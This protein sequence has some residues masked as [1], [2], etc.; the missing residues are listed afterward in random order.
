MELSR[1][2]TID[3][4]GEDVHLNLAESKIL[5]LLTIISDVNKLAPDENEQMNMMKTASE[6]HVASRI[7]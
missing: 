7:S 3:R 2:K 1:G 6:M 4:N 5:L